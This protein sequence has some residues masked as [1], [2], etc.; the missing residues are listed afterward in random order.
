[1][2]TAV[3]VLNWNGKAWLEKF[4]PNLVNHSQVAT[5]FVAD[6]ASTDDSVDYVKINFPTVKI[7]V[8]ASNGGYAKGYND[9]LKQIDAE[10][11]VLI[12]SDIEVTAGWLSPIISLMDS[13]KQIASCQPKILNYNSKT[14]FEYAGASG[15]FID[16]LGYPF[17]RG[18]IFDDLEQDKG[19]YNDAVEVFWATGACLFVRSTHFW[20][21][22]G[23]DEDFFAHQ[24]EIDLCWRLKNKGY[25]IMVQPKSV[26]YH[27][28]GGTLNAGSPFKTH[29]NFR[30]NLFM[31]FK[32][33]PIT[34]LFTTIPMRLVL[35]GVA[36]LTFLNKEK[37]L[38][39]VLAIAKAHFS[40]YFAIPNLIAKRQ[41]ISQKNSL[42]GKMNWSIL[43]K[44]K[45]NGIKQFSE[46]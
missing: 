30:N 34:S 10:Y 15:G 32:N 31:L 37:G 24:E 21:L 9:V 5:V 19:Q 1:M 7:I 23:L 43:V 3:V 29:L 28:G 13:D 35:D 2:K 46:L 44:N 33:L 20:E 36:A 38:E 26:V 27:V 16:N 42:V 11:F 40:F 45:M 4:L 39:H 8:N 14:K 18:R 22:G 6:N 17:C 25:K 41:K 12:N